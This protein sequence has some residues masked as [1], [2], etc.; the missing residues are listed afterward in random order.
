MFILLIEVINISCHKAAKS[1]KMVIFPIERFIN[2]NLDL[3]EL[4]DALQFADF[5]FTVEIV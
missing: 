5:L 2:E 3:I 4:G 1:H